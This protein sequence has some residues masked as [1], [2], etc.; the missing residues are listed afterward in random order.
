MSLVRFVG[1]LRFTRVV[2][3]IF[4]KTF[5]LLKRGLSESIFPSSMLEIQGSKILENKRAVV[6]AGMLPQEIKPPGDINLKS[7]HG[8]N[9]RFLP[10]RFFY[11]LE[12]AL[13]T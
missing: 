3:G 6:F 8:K 9:H 1:D 2:Y 11:F 10:E 5:A 12:S 4:I 13:R 7:A